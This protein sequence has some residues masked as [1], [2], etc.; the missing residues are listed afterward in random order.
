MKRRYDVVVIGSG[1]GGAITAGRLAQ[2]GLHV[3][4]LEQGQR[5]N[6]EQF[7]RTTGQVARTFWLPP[8]H[9]GFLEYRTFGRIDVIQGVGVGGGSLHYF[10]VHLRPDE[11][12]F[13]NGRWPKAI[14]RA[15][16]EPYYDL[17]QASLESRPLPMAGARTAP[18]RTTAFMDAAK[19]LGMRPRLVDI[20][21][22]TGPSRENH[23]RVAQE[24]CTYCGNCLLGC[25]VHAKNTLDITYIAAAERRH[26]TEV[27]PLHRVEGIAP[28]RT[29]YEVS[30]IDGSGAA[31][32]AGKVIGTRV[33][34]AGGALGSTE[35]L[36]R[37]RDKLKSLPKLSP[38]LGQW[39]SGNG[40]FLVPFATRTR[41]SIDPAF[42]PSITAAVSAQVGD[43]LITVEDLGLPD[44]F[45]WY[46]EGLVPPS[47]RRLRGLLRLASA[48]VLRSI[49]LPAV[50]SPVDRRIDALVGDGRTLDVLPYLGM[51]TDAADGVMRLR[52]GRLD[53]DWRHASS[54]RMFNDLEAL[55]RRIS[56]SA[57]GHYQTSPL[58]RWPLR[59]LLTAHPLGGCAIGDDP[60]TSVADHRG[61]VWNYPGLY[62]ADGAVVPSALAVNPSVTIGALAERTAFWILHDREMHGEDEAMP[63][64]MRA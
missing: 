41:Q 18:G 10:N 50:G 61:E 4:I 20:A 1:F 43:N 58:W 22:H 3:A 57:G 62:V 7:P 19:R 28:V 24:G 9:G 64:R 23:S 48:Y 53:I 56:K 30:F 47:H 60:R 6:K 44:P 12:I 11:R 2:S 45:F 34:V 17:V 14:N 13:R 25:H 15:V 35:L 54:R 52:R 33:I 46:L 29:G 16:L 42:G 59:K 55:I 36:L 21:V 37:C 49:G 31:P 32:R 5:W 40:D 8:K 51:G 63:S 26:G 27:Y 38:H 39:F